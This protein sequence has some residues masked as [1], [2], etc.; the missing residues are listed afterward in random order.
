MNTVENWIKKIDAAEAKYQPYYE[1]IKEIR[2][3]YKN[4]K[5]RNKQNVFWSTIETLKPFLYFKEPKPYIQLKRRMESKVDNIA[6]KILE[7]AL[8]WNMEKFD[9]DSVMKYVRNDFLLLGCGMAFERYVPTFKKYLT[10]DKGNAL[11]E[12]LDDEKVETVYINPEDFV[13]DV[14]KVNVFEDCEWIARKIFM[15]AEQVKKEFGT[16]ACVLLDIKEDEPEDKVFLI[17]EIFDKA[18][19]QILYLTKSCSHAFLK[20]VKDVMNLSGFYAMPKPLFL[21]LANDGLVPV[22]D[23]VELKPMLEELSGITSR[24]QLVMQA[25]KVSG[26]YDNSFPELASILNKDVTLVA[27]SD[28]DKLKESGGLSGIIDFAPIEQYVVALEA[29]ATRRADIMGQIYEMTGV[30]DIMRGTSDKTETATAVAKKTNFGTLRNQERQNDMVRFMTDLF[31]IKA[32]MICERFSKEKLKMFADENDDASDVDLAV[33][34]LKADKLRG[35]VLGLD[36]DFSFVGN[37]VESAMIG[38]ISSIHQLISGAFGIVSG[39]PLLLGIYRQML[40]NLAA[41]LPGAR[42]YA[43]VIEKVFDG[44]EKDLNKQM[45]QTPDLAMMQFEQ[46]TKKTAF[47]QEMKQKELALK[48]AE[49]ALKAKDQERKAMLENKEMDL[50]AELKREAL[51]NQKYEKTGTNI[52]T[53]RVK[54]F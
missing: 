47:E 48:E 31:K 23:Y 16:Q 46:N 28:F 43:P 30:S 17:Y 8:D 3:Y 54:E 22:P 44:I 18:G 4:E 19:K 52:T 42:L 35:L 41:T 10:D 38:T 14:E 29:L 37:N 33:D 39:Q 24:M 25:I 20:V 2:E 26:A 40:S 15:N 6:C 5:S 13:A 9:F 27:V 1:L 45:P 34:I 11:F 50:Q 36:T 12:V 7:R 49:L 32:E 21:G 53:G 51:K